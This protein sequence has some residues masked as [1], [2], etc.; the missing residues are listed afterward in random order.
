LEL[1]DMTHTDTSRQSGS[2]PQAHPWLSDRKLLVA[3]NVERT[4]ENDRALSE[5]LD[6][7][8]VGIDKILNLAPEAVLVCDAEGTI[9]L[10]NIMAE[11]LAQTSLRGTSLCLLPSIW[12]EM[13]DLRGHPVKANDLP[14]MK[15]LHG[16]IISAAEYRL[17]RWDTKTYE[18]LCSAVPIN[19]PN[20]SKI[21]GAVA[22]LTNITHFKRRSSKL[23]TAAVFTE[24][25]RMAADIHDT[26]CQSLSA[27]VLQIE[28]GLQRFPEGL[29]L[30]QHHLRLAQAA[31]RESLTEARRSMWTLTE[32][33]HE[34]GDLAVG[35]PAMVASVLRSMPIKVDFRIQAETR[36]L[37]RSLR[38]QVLR[39]AEEALRNVASHANA[40]S[41]SIE[42]TCT[43]REVHLCIRDDGKGFTQSSA[44]S[45]GRFGL[46]GMR[47]RAHR[48]GGKVVV[49]SE[50]GSGTRVEASIPVPIRKL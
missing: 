16:E 12:G 20:E 24:R 36:R 39:I 29:E 48:L 18:L 43:G 28:A 25:R 45:P 13:F 37:S 17:V 6:L 40:T 1:N 49:D 19:T 41:V 7:S 5:A 44:A 22:T 30:A 47:E 27:I 31:A 38:L 2:L 32:T 23:R 4:I 3:S 33:S 11:Q 34:I 14:L 35:I 10:A 26:L 46:I 50:L 15:A 42:L 21:V 9:A 8:G